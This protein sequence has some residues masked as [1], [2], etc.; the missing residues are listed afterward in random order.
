M[1]TYQAEIQSEREVQL[2]GSLKA[3]NLLF[4][5]LK[6]QS[7]SFKNQKEPHSLP[8]NLAHMYHF[9]TENEVELLLPVRKN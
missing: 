3:I 2:T 6:A 8:F 7:Q 5:E 9:L 1:K 4:K